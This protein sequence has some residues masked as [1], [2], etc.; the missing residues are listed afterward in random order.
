MKGDKWW[1]FLD[2][3]IENLI[4]G[5]LLLPL[6]LRAALR[7]PPNC[8]TVGTWGRFLVDHSNVAWVVF[9]S[10]AYL[11]GALSFV[12]GR[13]LLDP[14]CPRFPRPILFRHSRVNPLSGNWQSIDASYLKVM[15]AAMKSETPE[16]RTEI[17]TR[18]RRGRFI[19]VAILPAI[20]LCVITTAESSG[21]SRFFAF[22]GLL[23]VVWVGFLVVYAYAELCIY[24][25]ASPRVAP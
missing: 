2:R 20:L 6:L 3:H 23:V 5:M 22:A 25:E 4:P 18:R 17:H 14:I 10:G 9:L 1:G 7:T 8:S 24:Q 15:H 13:M 12:V 16:L 21:L 19:R 11:L